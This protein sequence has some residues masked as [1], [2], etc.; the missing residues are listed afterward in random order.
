MLAGTDNDYSVTC[1]TRERRAVRRVLQLTDAEPVRVGS[2]QCPWLGQVITG[3]FTTGGASPR[4]SRRPTLLPG[5]L[6]AYRVP[7]AELESITWSP[8]RSPTPT[9]RSSEPLP[10]RHAPAQAAGWACRLFF[11]GLSDPME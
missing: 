3:C 9:S 5:V 8:S 1:E 7:P 11:D 6:H 10:T 2:I 4:R